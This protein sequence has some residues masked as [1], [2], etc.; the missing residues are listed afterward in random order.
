MICV[1]EIYEIMKRNFLF[2]KKMILEQFDTSKG[3][4]NKDIDQNSM[5]YFVAKKILK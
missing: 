4:F 1:F 3:L 2:Q 5:K